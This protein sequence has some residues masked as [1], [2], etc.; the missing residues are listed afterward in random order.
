M[1]KSIVLLMASVISSV[2][3]SQVSEREVE[4]L[5][6]SAAAMYLELDY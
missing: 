1:K 2:S 4:N 5:V 3:Y 6:E